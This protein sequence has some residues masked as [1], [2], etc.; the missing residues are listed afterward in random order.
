MADKNVLEMMLSRYETRSGLDR[1]N[2]IKEVLQ[3]IVLCGLSRSGFFHNAAF[4]GGSA[5]RIF[6]QLDR[7]SEDLDFSLI[8][9]DS[10]YRLEEYFP[11]VKNEAASYG[12][13]VDVEENQRKVRGRHTSCSGSRV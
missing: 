11:A 7:F 5:L 12:L 6:Y 1:E 4:Y 2:A 10:D 9:P 8:E 13:H 3:E